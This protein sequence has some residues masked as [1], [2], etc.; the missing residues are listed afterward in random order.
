MASLLDPRT[1][2][3]SV[4]PPSRPA[5][6]AYP[7]TNVVN[8]SGADAHSCPLPTED[9]EFTPRLPRCNR[10]DYSDSNPESPWARKII[11]SL[12]GGGVR[13]YSSLLI[14]KRVLFLIEQIERGQRMGYD[15]RQSDKIDDEP[16]LVRYKPN[17]SSAEYPW[18]T[19]PAQGDV[20]VVV[21]QD[22]LPQIEDE[23]DD[24]AIAASVD[25]TFQAGT[26]VTQFK[27]HHY[28]DYIAG[29]STGG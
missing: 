3:Q 2:T 20:P 5:S 23:D 11:L 15:L 12:D 28:I 29:T 17:R 10:S 19:P 27:A 8:D 9:D 25:E 4:Q 6:S 13:G 24:D 14:L 1:A 18:F 21:A 16:N 22:D 26:L 7:S